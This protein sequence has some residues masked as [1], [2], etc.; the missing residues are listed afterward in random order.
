MIVE[1]KKYFVGYVNHFND[2]IKPLLIELL[3]LNR[4]KKSFE[5]VE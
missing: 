2:N 1:K 4:S 3:K 5:K